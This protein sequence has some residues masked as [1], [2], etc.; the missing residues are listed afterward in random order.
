MGE[1][2]EKS[3]KIFE[4]IPELDAFKTAKEYECIARVL[5]LGEW[6]SVVWMG[7]LFALD[8]DYGEHW[9]DNDDERE[10]LA[11]KVAQKSNLPPFCKDYTEIM[12]RW[13]D[14]VDN[15]L[16]KEYGVNSHEQL[17]IIKPSR[18]KKNHA[19]HSQ[20]QRK[21][22]WT[23]ALESLHL[24]LETAF[25]EAIDAY[26]F[27]KEMHDKDSNSPFKEMN[28][29]RR[30][31]KIRDKFSQEEAKLSKQ[32]IRIFD[33]HQGIDAFTVTEEYEQLA[34]T[35]KLY[36]DGRGKTRQGNPVRWIGRLFT[37]DRDY[38]KLWCENWQDREFI[39]DD[40]ETDDEE[41]DEEKL[42]GYYTVNPDRFCDGDDG[43]CHLSAQRKRFWT[44]VLKSLHLSLDTLF[45]EARTKYLRELELVKKYPN[46]LIFEGHLHGKEYFDL[47]KTIKGITEIY[48]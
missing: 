3:V 29:E 38:G 27:D 2:E 41:F 17:L 45:D 32:M 37:M 28:I 9:F 30:I 11:K 36:E 44:D 34:L 4:Y 25:E 40:L 21:R 24:S 23:D 48:T 14:L 16:K 5:N 22:F 42:R 26:E 33:Y 19:C 13:Y 46:E 12:A 7:R 15:V 43:P 20:E 47:E 39:Q 35:L 10:E 8:N 6:N 18:F 31:K 1:Q